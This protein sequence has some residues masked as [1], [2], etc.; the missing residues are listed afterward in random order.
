MNLFISLNFGVKTPV[1]STGVTGTDPEQDLSGRARKTL[2]IW[3]EIMDDIETFGKH[4]KSYGKWENVV[5]VEQSGEIIGT[6]CCNVGIAIINHP[7]LVI[8]GLV[9]YC[10]TN[11]IYLKHM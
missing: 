2:A 7:F 11:I 6:Y 5:M 10:Y 1:S 8:R 9:Y 3:A 4:G